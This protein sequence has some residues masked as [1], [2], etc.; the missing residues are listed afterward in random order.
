MDF[1]DIPDWLLDTRFLLLLSVV[2]LL[3]IDQIKTRKPKNFPP[4]PT[5]LPFIGN[6]LNLDYSQPHIHF[7]KMSNKYGNIYSLQLAGIP[8]VV[9]N[10]YA[11]VKEGFVDQGDIFVDR[12]AYP[13][14]QKINKCQ[15][16]AFNNGYSWKQQRR[17]TLSTLRNFGLGKKT[18]E[19]SITEEFTFLH[20]AFI[21][22]KGEP[23][24]PHHVIINAV[25][26]IICSLVFGQRFEY[27]DER[28]LNM[29]NLLSKS[30]K[31]E[32]SVW[33]QLYNAFPR[34][35]DLIP[36]PHKEM[37]SYFHQVRVFIREEIEKHRADWD[38]SSPRDFIDCYLSEIEKRTD[39]LEA[40]F[41]LEG[42][43][44]TVLD[45]FVAGTETTS[46]TLL[47]SFVY[48][49]KYPEIQE[50]VH[51][52]IDRVIGR[53]RR[54]CMADRANMPYTDAVIHETQRM[55]NIVP[56][57]VPRV[58]SKDTNLGGY[59]IP[60][61]MQVLP[62]MT[63]VLYDE[64]QFKSPHSFYPENFLNTQGEFIKP[65]GFIPFSVGK[66]ICPGES[67]ARME[68]FIFFTSVLQS[69][70]LSP[71]VGTKCSLDFDFGVTLSPKPF[72]MNATPRF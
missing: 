20:K 30:L 12:P 11:M 8:V 62:N 38:P 40:G 51:A 24:N 41:H 44:H 35:M 25:S 42:L 31:L 69:F 23:F 49:M 19:S 45:L 48:M 58:I 27:T 2:F 16:I 36:G 13:V 10:S 66:R 67:L 18:L 26:N 64:T 3:V 32:G 57:S 14:F 5:P 54:P 33:A 50:K 65:D 56:F 7:T 9:L 28:F 37:F 68:L 15:G 43:C 61:G 63:S 71:P 59:F 70:T 4:G 46:T 29:L 53:L 52:E 22:I 6:F 1:M 21:N 60:K 55:G 47:W 17:F 34:V 39:D 72:K